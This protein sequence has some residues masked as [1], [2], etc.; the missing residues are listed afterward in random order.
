[1]SYIYVHNPSAKYST[2]P[3]YSFSQNKFTFV[4]LLFQFLLTSL[5]THKTFILINLGL[6]NVSHGVLIF[7]PL[8]IISPIHSPTPSAPTF[9]WP[10]EHSVWVLHHKIDVL[11]ALTPPPQLSLPIL[12]PQ[13][14]PELEP[15]SPHRPH[16]LR[17][18]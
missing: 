6:L 1:M 15:T 14:L 10:T 11:A 17:P 2:T 12:C 9:F 7:F 8:I 4:H 18:H 13:D 16:K 5:T 3:F